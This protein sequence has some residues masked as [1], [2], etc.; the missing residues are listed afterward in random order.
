MGGRGGASAASGGGNSGNSEPIAFGN[1]TRSQIESSIMD[2][3]QQKL[4]VPLTGT[5]SDVA[6]GTKVRNI[7]GKEMI[8]YTFSRTSDGNPINAQ[9]A[10]SY[11]NGTKSQIANFVIDRAKE[12]SYGNKSLHQQ[13]LDLAIKTQN[14][15]VQRANRM[16][17]IFTKNTSA[18]F[19]KTKDSAYWSAQ[20]HDYI[21]GKIDKINWM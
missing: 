20:M 1:M 7:I 14:D 13:K 4:N 10:N 21:D 18:K 19:W 9:Y 15:L 12:T 16:A 6:E 17:N 3:K 8:Q 5:S 11:I 2:F